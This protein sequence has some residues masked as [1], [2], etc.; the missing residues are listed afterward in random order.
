VQPEQAKAMV[1]AAA[2]SEGSKATV[3]GAAG[4]AASAA[5][6]AACQKVR[7]V[8]G[9]VKGWAS[10]EAGVGLQGRPRAEVG[11]QPP[12]ARPGPKACM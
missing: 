8:E 10:V 6:A 1:V 12:L 4:A 9:P 3:L 5:G 7:L 2:I 11:S